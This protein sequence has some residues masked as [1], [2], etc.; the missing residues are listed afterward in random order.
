[1]IWLWWIPKLWSELVGLHHIMQLLRLGNLDSNWSVYCEGNKNA[2][3]TIRNSG[4]IVTIESIDLIVIADWNWNPC[5]QYPWVM[6]PSA[7]K[8]TTWTGIVNSYPSNLIPIR[9]WTF[10]FGKFQLMRYV[11][12]SCD[13]CVSRILG[14]WFFHTNFINS[15]FYRWKTRCKMLYMG[16]DGTVPHIPVLLVPG[17]QMWVS[18]RRSQ[19]VS[20]STC[21]SVRQYQYMGISTS[22][23]VHGYQYMGISPSTPLSS[24]SHSRLVKW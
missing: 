8:I 7:W 6:E 21:V 13:S 20:I 19:Y 5:W 12:I 1:M 15:Y 17:H 14:L 23:S 22:V 4:I 11:I 9:M 2:Q 16:R 10:D 3:V 18:V 24:A